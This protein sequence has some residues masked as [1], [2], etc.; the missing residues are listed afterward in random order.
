[1]A[2]LNIFTEQFTGRLKRTIPDHLNWYKEEDSFA[3]DFA[4]GTRWDLPTNVEL[5]LPASVGIS[6]LLLPPVDSDLK[7]LENSIRLHRSLAGLSHAQARDPRLWARLAHV[8]FWSYMRARWPVERHIENRARAGRYIEER[9]F[10]PRAEGRA[11]LRN[12]IARLWWYAQLTHDETRSN[13]YELTGVLLNS[14]DITQQILERSLG[15]CRSVL[16]AF[17]EFLLQN[18]RLLEGGELNRATIRSLAKSLN[19]FGG[20]AVLDTLAPSTLRK[21]LNT[22][23]TRIDARNTT[24][25]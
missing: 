22:E 12:G 8:E 2:T 21:Y 6:T 5:Q 4:A 7:D 16:V 17:L 9:Y 19:L 3:E 11:L 13:P 10:V 18:P 20:V 23:L 15:R 24:S 1:V 25:P 14:L